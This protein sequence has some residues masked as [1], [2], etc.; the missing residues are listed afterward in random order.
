M[1]KHKIKMNNVVLLIQKNGALRFEFDLIF[2]H[3]VV[4]LNIYRIITMRFHLTYT[5]FYA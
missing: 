5:N 1:F 3:R 4:I 2:A